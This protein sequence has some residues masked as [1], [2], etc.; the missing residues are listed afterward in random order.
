VLSAEE[1]GAWVNTAVFAREQAGQGMFLTELRPAVALFMRFTGIDFETDQAG[2]QLDMFL[3]RV[4]AVLRLYEGTL[5]QLTIGDKGSYL[6]AAFGAPMTHEDDARRAM[7]AALDIRHAA[8]TLPYLEP[9]Q[10]G[11]TRG[12]MRTGPLC[13]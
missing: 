12:V 6:Y 1:L 4:Q 9:V 10:I 3:R 13:Q 5:I 11:L 2:E 7:K 8:Q